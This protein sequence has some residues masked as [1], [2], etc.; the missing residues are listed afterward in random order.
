LTVVV[1]SEKG[2]QS[3]QGKKRWLHAHT[4]GLDSP[5]LAFAVQRR[6]RRGD[7]GVLQ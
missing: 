3:F 2:I 1:V 6:R 5:R 7:E 4:V